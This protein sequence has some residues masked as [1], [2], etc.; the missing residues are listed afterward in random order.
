MKLQYN[1]Q[2]K[3]YMYVFARLCI[4]KCIFHIISLVQKI[5]E[6]RRNNIFYDVFITTC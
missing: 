6:E 2:P 1:R 3:L 5:F 4:I